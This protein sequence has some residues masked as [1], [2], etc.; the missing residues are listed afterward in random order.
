MEDEM[1]LQ[2]DADNLTRRISMFTKAWKKRNPDKT[3]TDL[4][5]MMGVQQPALRTWM[6]HGVVPSARFIPGICRALKITPDR[7]FGWSVKTPL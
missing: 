6:E 4:A 1:R 7:L 3:Y 2:Q 5:K